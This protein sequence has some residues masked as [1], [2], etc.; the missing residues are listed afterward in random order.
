MSSAFVMRLLMCRDVSRQLSRER[1]SLYRSSEPVNRPEALVTFTDCSF[2]ACFAVSRAVSFTVDAC[3]AAAAAARVPS[4]ITH[5]APAS[6]ARFTLGP[7]FAT[8]AG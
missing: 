1:P 6:T 4:P 2:A 3:L 8:L 5:I 7:L